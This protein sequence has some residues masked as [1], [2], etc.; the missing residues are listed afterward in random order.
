MEILN[1]KVLM[2]RTLK[3]LDYIKMNDPNEKGLDGKCRAQTDKP[4]YAVTQ[5][6]NS[7]LI[8]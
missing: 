1:Y 6:V 4:P 7:Y 3:D 8:L 5:R 2:R